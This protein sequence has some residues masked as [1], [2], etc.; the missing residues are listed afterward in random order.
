M[1]TLY[2]Y[3]YEPS[4]EVLHVA[5]VAESPTSKDKARTVFFIHNPQV[6]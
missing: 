4:A 6:A 5:A 2:L 3:Q 1:R